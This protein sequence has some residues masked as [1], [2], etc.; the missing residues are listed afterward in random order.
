MSV[1][2][3]TGR[4]V[5]VTGATGAIGHS[6][7]VALAAAGA[8]VH[9]LIR[10]PGEVPAAAVKHIGDITDPATVAAALPG[11]DTVVHLAALLHISDPT[12]ALEGQYHR[13]NDQATADLVSACVAAGVR[14]IVHIST[15]AVYGQGRPGGP[16]LDETAPCAPS[17]AYGRT[18]LA[19]ERHVLAARGAADDR[20]GVVLRLGAVY[21]VGIKGN[22]RRLVEALARG[23]YVHVGAGRNRRVLVHEQDV[24]DAVVLAAHH[25]AAAGRIFNV[26][27]GRL[28]ELRDIVAAICRALERPLPRVRVPVSLARTGAMGVEV[29]ARLVRR[30][31]PVTRRTIETLVEDV[32]VDGGRLQRDLGFAPRFDLERGWRDVVER[33]RWS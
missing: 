28:H 3:L 2:P 26:T 27:D 12:R 15:I 4:H 6:V 8:E 23:R 21:G 32:A 10:R 19:S 18:K 11:I 29:V 30:R 33:M 7:T 13:V 1:T 9:A 5:L 24:A 25:P 16:P 31:A 17:T 22:Y 14:R 20:L